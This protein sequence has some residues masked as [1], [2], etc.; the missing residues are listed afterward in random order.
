MRV[1]PDIATRRNGRDGA[2][3]ATPAP[4]PAARRAT[5]RFSWSAPARATPT[6]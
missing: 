2:T 4:A 6:C 3:G 5:A 1:P